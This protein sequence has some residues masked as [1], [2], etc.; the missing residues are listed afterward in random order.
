MGTH[1]INWE[2]SIEERL[3]SLANV[4][5]ILTVVILALIHLRVVLQPFIV[6]IMVFFLL[7][8]AV[9][10][11]EKRGL[12]SLPSYL[13]VVTSF[14]VLVGLTGW[15]LYEDLAKIIDL[16]PAHLENVKNWMNSVEGQ[17]FLG[18]PISFGDIGDS[19]DGNAVRVVLLSMFGGI[20]SFL[21]EVVKVL[22]FL[23]FI[24]LEAESLPKRF[25]AA[26]PEEVNERLM[27]MLSDIK[28]GINRYVIVKTLVSLGTALVTAVI[29]M[30]TGIPGWFLWSVLTFILNYVPYIGSMIAVFP[31]LTLSILTF[32]PTLALVV[33]I[34]LLANQQVWGSFVEPKMFGSSLDISPVVLLL[35]TAFWF[36]LWGIMGMVLA[37]PMAVITKIVLQNIESTRP[38]A[39][40]LSERPPEEAE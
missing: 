14:T 40:L 11:L 5:I 31:P 20:G 17:K 9:L 24:I 26:Y 16:L 22:I 28:M 23:I 1:I 10:Q 13:V 7:Q 29:L 38:I 27:E 33:T 6:A 30:A 8:P 21:S 19:L 15:W 37:I 4:A 18:V 39:I 2:T 12:S 35:L 3:R 34:L 36:W 25:A 32:D